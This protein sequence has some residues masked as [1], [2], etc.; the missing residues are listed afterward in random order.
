MQTR[1]SK[2]ERLERLE[3]IN[4]RRN[5]AAIEAVK[6]QFLAS[7]KMS[8][9]RLSE[10]EKYFLA[11]AR[12]GQNGA[13]K[14]KKQSTRNRTLPTQKTGAYICPVCNE[15]TKFTY[16]ECGVQANKAVVTFS[17]NELHE[18]MR[19]YREKLVSQQ[20]LWGGEVGTVHAEEYKQYFRLTTLRAGFGKRKTLELI[21][22]VTGDIYEPD[23]KGGKLKTG[24]LFK[25]Y[26]G[27]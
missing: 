20:K 15:R 25:L 16:C 27:G 23:G 26:G 13:Q 9:E 17:S 5:V 8:N 6:A 12:N 14:A 22:A 4:S 11:K 24:N 18:R 21:H 3:R 1:M 19:L 2:A 10:R 7:E